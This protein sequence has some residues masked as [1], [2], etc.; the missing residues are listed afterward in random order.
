M[1]LRADRHHAVVSSSCGP[2]TRAVAAM[3]ATR[4]PESSRDL[5]PQN[6]DQERDEPGAERVGGV[7]GGNGF[8]H[9]VS[10]PPRRPLIST[11]PGNEPE[12]MRHLPEL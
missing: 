5:R 12:E 4:E 3:M 1:V 2:F 6:A 7:D 11:R 8:Q 10:G 9:K